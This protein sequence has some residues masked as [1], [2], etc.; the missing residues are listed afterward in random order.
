MGSEYSIITEI[1]NNNGQTINYE[2]HIPLTE[3]FKS[4]DITSWTRSESKL[5]IEDTA[6]LWDLYGEV[7]GVILGDEKE[8]E[9]RITFSK[10]FYIVAKCDN[11]VVGGLWIEKYKKKECFHIFCNPEYKGNGVAKNLEKMMMDNNLLSGDLAVCEWSRKRESGQSD[12]FR[13][14]GYTIICKDY[15]NKAVKKIK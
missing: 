10:N 12:F 9:E 1:V 3:W 8:K 15:T 14:L 4:S 6:N 2:L 11:K 13:K 5:A 7:T